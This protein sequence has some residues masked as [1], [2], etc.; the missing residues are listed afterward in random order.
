MRATGWELKKILKDPVVWC[1]LA[2][3]L[4]LQSFGIFAGTD[5][6]NPRY[7]PSAPA[8]RA[9]L[10]KAREDMARFAGPITQAWID[11][12][13]KEAEAILDDPGYRVSETEAE[14]IVEAY[15]SRYGYQAEAVRE[16]RALFLNEAGRAEYET[17][18]DAMVASNFYWNARRQGEWLAER[19]LRAAPGADGE[20]LAAA[21]C[22]W[23]DAFAGEYTAEY[24]YSFGYQRVRALMTLYPYT[25]GAVILTALAPLFSAEYAKR[26]DAL[27]LTSQNGR[28]KTA[29]AKLRAGLLTALAVWGLLTAWDLVA[30]FALYGTT[31][32]EAFWQDWLIVVAPFPWTQGEVTLVSLVTSLLGA[33]YFAILVMLISSRAGHP[34]TSMAAGAALLLLPML[35]L[36]VSADPLADM[37]CG[38]FPSWMMMGERI[39]QGFSLFRF[40][41]VSVPYQCAALAV[42]A[43]ASLFAC[44]MMVR[45]FS[46]RQVTQ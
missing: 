45:F 39:W 19:Y 1:A 10:R 5:G 37:I 28:R 29:R 17:Y 14:A 9:E 43:F 26:T 11:R 33:L 27:V 21:A 42:A 20:A 41:G 44:V 7:M 15:V 2:V 6:E 36:V 46:G 23:Y 35:D 31:G 24:H 38:L 22:G 25:M 13:Q 4:L 3:A 8:F 18:E 40:A 12:L 16:R 34:F 32:W 30:I